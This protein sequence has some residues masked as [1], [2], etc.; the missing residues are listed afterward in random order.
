MTAL[1]QLEGGSVWDDEVY[2][3]FR[4]HVEDEGRLLS[5]YRE[6]AD[7]P[8]NPDVAYLIR[9]IMDDERRHHAVFER[10]ANTVRSVVELEPSAAGVPDIPLRRDGSRA[11]RRATEQLLR[12][13]REDARRLRKL[14]HALRPVDETTIW[15]LLVETMEL[16][17]RKHI[18]IL[19]HILAI[20]GG[21]FGA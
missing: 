15:P 19:K 8:S 9:M 2:N 20:S 17:T 12:F 3:A 7:D 13:E 1:E 4:S 6:L 11:L 21:V 14:R 5:A 16:D 18:L 10:L